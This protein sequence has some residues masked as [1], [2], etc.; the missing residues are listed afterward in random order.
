MG[1]ELSR[2]L[3]GAIVMGFYGVDETFPAWFL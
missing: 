2:P 3:S 1:L